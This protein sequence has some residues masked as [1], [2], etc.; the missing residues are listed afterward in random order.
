MEQNLQK[1]DKGSA[2]SVAIDG[3]RIKNVRETKK[4][5]QLY[6]ANVVGVTTDTISRWENNRYPTI[7]RDNAEKLAGALEVELEDILREEDV[8]E[9]GVPAET[10]APPP[11]SPLRRFLIPTVAGFVLLSVLGFVI[12]RSLAPAPQAVRWA[13]AFAAPGEVVPVQIKITRPQGKNTGFILKEQLPDGWRL[14]S[15]A[16]PS[17]SGD[18]AGSGL[19]WLIP[20][21]GAS[22]TVSYTAQVPLS[23]PLRGVAKFR[24]E[25]V[26]PAPG[27][28]RSESVAG[29]SSVKIGTF[30]WADRNGDNRIDDDEIMPAYYLCEDMKGLGLDWKT[31]EAVWSGKGYRWDP[32]SGFT[33]L[34]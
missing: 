31:I 15:A 7:R 32:K 24:G 11:R 5:T 29:D 3:S 6:V 18:P 12:L 16:P 19:K 9:P 30:H 10:S 4:L 2:P 8:V 25:M 13:P 22:V 33:V 21:G 20:G 26:L 17:S 1:N 28:N 14:V 23:A 27:V 34:R